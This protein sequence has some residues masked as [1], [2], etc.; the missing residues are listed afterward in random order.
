MIVDGTNKYQ[1]TEHALT[2]LLVCR[3]CSGVACGLYMYRPLACVMAWAHRK[4]EFSKFEFK[5]LQVFLINSLSTSD[6]GPWPIGLLIGRLSIACC[7]S[8]LQAARQPPKKALEA[9]IPIVGGTNKYQLIEH[10]PANLLVCRSCSE[11]GHFY[12]IHAH[13]HVS[14]LIWNLFLLYMPAAFYEN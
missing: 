8:Q 1:W 7:N 10:T 12:P 2:N 6:R 9:A 4:V 13:A 5:K 11:A 14:M 3:S